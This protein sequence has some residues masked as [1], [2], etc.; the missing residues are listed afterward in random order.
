MGKQQ[1][2]HLNRGYL[3][4]PFGSAE[5]AEFENSIEL[6]N[7][8]AQRSEGYI[9]NVDVDP[10]AARDAFFWP[11]ADLN[12]QAVTLSIW[13]D[14]QLLQAFVHNTIHGRFLQRRHEW[15]ETVKGP[16][17][18]VWP[19]PL[20]HVPTL[21]EAKVAYDRLALEGPGPAAF[22]FRWLAHNSI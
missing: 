13:S 11:E 14:P 3:R 16:S 10:E 21:A 7:S 5:I 15:F 18:V 2:G 17:Y 1:Y 19:M 8:V 6:V 22:D 4:G 9:M 12:R 20:G